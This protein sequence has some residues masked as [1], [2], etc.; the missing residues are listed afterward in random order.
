LSKELFKFFPK[1]KT[2]KVGK[3]DWSSKL[4][5]KLFGKN[6]KSWQKRLEQFLEKSWQKILDQ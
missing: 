3:K 1:E 2:Q 4:C 5:S 6:P